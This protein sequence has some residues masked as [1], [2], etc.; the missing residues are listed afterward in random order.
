MDRQEAAG[1]I[2]SR[3]HF[4]AFLHALQCNAADEPER[5]QTGDLPSD[6]RTLA[7]WVEDMDGFYWNGGRPAPD[8]PAWRTLDE[9]L[10]A[11][12]VYE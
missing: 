6:L 9:M 4:I 11:A 1:Q 8:Q 12:R 3:E 7:A 5:W 2:D 10:R